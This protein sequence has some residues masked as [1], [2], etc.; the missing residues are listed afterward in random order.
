MNRKENSSAHSVCDHDTAHCATLAR[1]FRKEQEDGMSALPGPLRP[2]HHDG[3]FP[4]AVTH[5]Q[6]MN[7]QILTGQAL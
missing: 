1:H 2:P 3:C 7:T 4:E 6:N 5:R